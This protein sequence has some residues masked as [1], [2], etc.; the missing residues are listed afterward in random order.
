LTGEDKQPPKQVTKDTVISE[1]AEKGHDKN[2]VEKL[3]DLLDF[4]SGKAELQ[5]L[6]LKQEFDINP[7]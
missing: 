5:M 3:Y 6:K 4:D 2:L 1:L 7:F